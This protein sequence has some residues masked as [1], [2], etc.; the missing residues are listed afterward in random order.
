[1]LPMHRLGE[2]M[3]FWFLGLP[4]SLSLPFLFR[5]W[6]SAQSQD[7]HTPCALKVALWRSE[8]AQRALG[9]CLCFHRG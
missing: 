6:P 7:P 1:M 9:L 2:P 5:T 8:R 4:W 3:C